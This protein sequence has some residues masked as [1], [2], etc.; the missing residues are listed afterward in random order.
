MVPRDREICVSTPFSTLTGELG[1][2]SAQSKK[3]PLRFRRLGT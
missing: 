3:G 2:M 1:A